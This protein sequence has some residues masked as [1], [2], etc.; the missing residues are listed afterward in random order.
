VVTGTPIHDV[1]TEPVGAAPGSAGGSQGRVPDVRL[2]KSGLE[3]RGA[4]VCIHPTN[5]GRAAVEYGFGSV[6]PGCKGLLG[7]GVVADVVLT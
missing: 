5:V 3:R 1:I 6:G 2:G 4:A 7:D